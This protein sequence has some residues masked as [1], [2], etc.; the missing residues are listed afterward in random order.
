MREIFQIDSPYQGSLRCISPDSSS[1]AITDSQVVAIHDCDGKH[2][3]SIEIEQERNIFAIEWNSAGNILCVVYEDHDEVTLWYKSNNEI[4]L[5]RSG[6]KDISLLLWSPSNDSFILGTKKGNLV[7]CNVS[8]NNVDTILG[9]HSGEILCGTWTNDGLIVLGS[10]DKTISF[11]RTDGGAIQTFSLPY[12]PKNISHVSSNGYCFVSAE[13]DFGIWFSDASQENYSNGIQSEPA[14]TIFEED[15]G[16]VV[17]HFWQ[18]NCKS[19]LIGTSHGKFIRQPNPL[20]QDA[21]DKYNVLEYT[22]P[23]GTLSKSCAT[24]SLVL[25]G[26]NNKNTCNLKV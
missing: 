16:S 1:V 22:I 18:P 17:C 19:I 6:F 21:E 24:Q 10:D 4:H 8:K 5:I 12:R 13:L 7:I 9:K 26:K 3:C 23:L 25:V 2:L 14:L 20:L 15:L 11:S